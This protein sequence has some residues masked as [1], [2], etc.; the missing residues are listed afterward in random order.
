[1]APR[2]HVCAGGRHAREHRARVAGYRPA[3]M[4]RPAGPGAGP[5]D[6]SP[7]PGPVAV[8]LLVGLPRPADAGARARALAAVR[9]QLDHAL[10]P[11]D[12]VPSDHARTLGG[13]DL[14]AQLRGACVKVLVERVLV[15]E[16]AHEP[17][18]S[19]GDPQRVH[20]QVLV[21]G[22]PDR[23]RL[24]VLGERRAA[25]IAAAWPDPPLEPGLVPW[26][27]LPPLPP[28][29]PPAGQVAA[30]PARIEPGRCPAAAPPVRTAGW[31]GRGPA[32]G[33]RPGAVR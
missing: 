14:L 23:H 20:R 7:R 24:E 16:A 5:G 31:P 3:S 17:A 10:V 27:H 25:Q 2:H 11:R 18:A 28:S 13:V 21:L 32:R 29:G 15:L 9:G 26:A 12:V 6:A 4:R 8:T 22:H 30:P 33:N 1:C 19:A